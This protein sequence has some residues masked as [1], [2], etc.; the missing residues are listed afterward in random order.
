MS[1]PP[2]TPSSTVAPGAISTHRAVLLVT[3]GAALW[4]VYWV[5]IR[6]IEHLG[7]AS[8]W[9][10]TAVT[11]AAAP[12]GLLVAVWLRAPRLTGMQRCGAIFCGAALTLYGFSLANTDVV[13]A[14]LLFYLSP[15]W[16]L[17]IE[18]AL[19]G[20][21]WTTRTTLAV[22]A[23]ALGM[24]L[25]FRGELPLD[26]LG[27]LGDWM[28]VGAGLAWSIGSAIIFARGSVAASA[29]TATAL[30][31]AAVMSV[32]LSL[33]L[34]QSGTGVSTTPFSPDAQ[35][36][37]LA[38]TVVAAGVVYLTPVML[39][40]L[41]GTSQIS[42]ATLGFILTAEIISGV[43]SSALFLGERFG[44]PEAAGTVLIIGGAVIEVMR[45]RDDPVTP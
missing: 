26:G 41:W 44:L 28:A 11:L 32:L 5:P 6:A 31:A 17:L 33:A 15:I 8:A 43:A 13:R 42:P 4:G 23:A 18:T 30:A 35:L 36:W 16:S 38:A 9:S 22:L 45:K 34:A 10:S 21:R 3:L 14:I 7:L 24:L 27:A 37:A 39:V 40:T 25:I 12:V 20:R 19:F 2:V 1:S 29:L